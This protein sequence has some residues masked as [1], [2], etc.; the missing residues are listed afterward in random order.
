MKK[1][2]VKVVLM[3][4]VL[5]ILGACSRSPSTQTSGEKEATEYMGKK[6]TPISQQNN[7]ALA[8]T[9][10]IDKQTYTLVV[11]GAV[12]SPLSLSYND[13]MSYPQ[14]SKL[15]DLDC[16]EGWNF[17]AKWTGPSLI[18]IL[19]EA[20][21]KSEAQIVIFHTADVPEGYTSLDL[22]Y[23]YNKNIIIALKLN[24]VTL[25]AERGFPFQ[26][27]A[28]SKYGYK[29]A[30]WV[31]RIEVSENTTFR[32]YWESNGFNNNA[33]VGGP[34]FEFPGF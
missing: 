13:L 15:T 10:F 17:T 34:G 25:P 9:Q 31:T 29:W 20:G 27:V 23:I 6:L 30:K 8:G 21:V 4:L 19:N 5:I 1:I 3:S 32:G 26:V 16:V 11:D 14:E 22:S 28:E 7:N 33:D 24:D 12:E 2:F 18:S